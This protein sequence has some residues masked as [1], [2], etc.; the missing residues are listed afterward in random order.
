MAL[1][2]WPDEQ[3][4][5]AWYHGP[6]YRPY[7]DQR[8][9]ASRTS[10]V[11]VRALSPPLANQPPT[12]HLTPI[13]ERGRLFDGRHANSRRSGRARE[14]VQMIADAAQNWKPGVLVEADR[15]WHRARSSRRAAPSF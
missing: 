8:H 2:A 12:P 4:R 9:R 11:S 15:G 3:T 13:A 5:Q 14:R 7:R 10:N 1:M 6:L